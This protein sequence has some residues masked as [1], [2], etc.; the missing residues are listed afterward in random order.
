MPSAIYGP[1]DEGADNMSTAIGQG[2]II[3]GLTISHIQIH[4]LI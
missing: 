3:E 1:T 2:P 4:E